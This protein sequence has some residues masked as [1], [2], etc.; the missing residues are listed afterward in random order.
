MY[1]SFTA[2]AEQF[3]ARSTQFA[4]PFGFGQNPHV[5]GQYATI[6]GYISGLS[7]LAANAAQS[8]SDIVLLQP[9]PNSAHFPQLKQLFRQDE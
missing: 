7:Q 9:K 1:R 6:I 2:I 4:P 3:S 8:S 5:R